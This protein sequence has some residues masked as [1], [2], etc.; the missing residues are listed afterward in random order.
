MVTYTNWLTGPHSLTEDLLTNLTLHPPFLPPARPGPTSST[1]TQQAP[2]GEN[3][4]PGKNP[5]DD[6]RAIVNH[7]NEQRY[8]IE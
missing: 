8:I 1:T 4:N 2:P 6:T 3:N 7:F 5:D